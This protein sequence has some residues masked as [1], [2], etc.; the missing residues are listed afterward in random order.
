MRVEWD[1]KLDS[2]TGSLGQVDFD[3]S[4]NYI[5]NGLYSQHHSRVDVPKCLW[6]IPFMSDP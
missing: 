5:N 2:F 1:G 6:D 4:L 3:I